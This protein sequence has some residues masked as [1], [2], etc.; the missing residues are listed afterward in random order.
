[1]D[2]IAPGE[3]LGRRVNSSRHSRRCR[4]SRVPLQVFMQKPNVIH[5]SVDRLSVAPIEE[6]TAIAVKAIEELN[7]NGTG[8]P[9]SFYGWAVVTKEKAI[10]GGRKA[11][12]SPT[13]DNPYHADIILP[14][15]VATNDVKQ[16]I[17]AQQLADAAQWCGQAE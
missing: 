13:D 15:C 16:K 17:H 4:R 1:M 2:V 8:K 9:R 5:I 7:Q 6:T 14:R 11:E 12:A 3:E 10:E